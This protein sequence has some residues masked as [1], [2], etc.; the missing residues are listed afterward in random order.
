MP[1]I[2]GLFTANQFYIVKRL[3]VNLEIRVPT[4][5]LIGAEGEQLGIM[6]RDAAMVLASESGLDLAEVAPNVNPPVCKILDYGKYQ[7]HQKK[8]EMKHRRMQRK[9]E[10]KG[11]RIGFKIGDHDLEIKANQAQKFLK[12]GNSVKVTLLFRGREAA[13]KDLGL[14]KMMKFYDGVKDFGK[15]ED[16]PKKQGNAM[17]MVITPKNN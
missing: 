5:R 2:L 1:I 8:V 10:I 14:A 16:N 7:Y 13:Y 4:V 15:M 12:E 9:A 11:I 6:S 17:L 3:R